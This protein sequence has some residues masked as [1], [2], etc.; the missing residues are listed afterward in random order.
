MLWQDT[1]VRMVP[2]TQ[3]TTI[4]SWRFLL[5]DST[6]AGLYYYLKTPIAWPNYY[7][8]DSYYLTLPLLQN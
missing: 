7:L 6:I 8:E 5:L 1:N 3:Q 2:A 4:L